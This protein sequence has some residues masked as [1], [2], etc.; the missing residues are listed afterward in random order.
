[1]AK[2]CRTCGADWV[3]CKVPARDLATVRRSGKGCEFWFQRET[4]LAVNEMVYQALVDSISRH[5][6]AEDD[7]DVIDALLAVREALTCISEP[8]T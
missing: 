3:Y 2:T 5:P 8:R 4:P 7:P 6:T 1:M